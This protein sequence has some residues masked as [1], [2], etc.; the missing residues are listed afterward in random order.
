MRA[1]ER[2]SEMIAPFFSSIEDGSRGPVVT[3]MVRLRPRRSGWRVPGRRQHGCR[4]DL[5]A[6]G[7]VE[8]GR[9]GRRCRSARFA[10]RRRA[11][12]SSGIA[13]VVISAARK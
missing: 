6:A 8:R 10:P 7:A 2:A 12:S 3:V 9:V 13:A 5:W 4:D 11:A 1:A